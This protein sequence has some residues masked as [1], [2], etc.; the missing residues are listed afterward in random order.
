M[1]GVVI[2]GY[3]WMVK[4]WVIFGFCFFGYKNYTVNVFYFNNQKKTFAK[5]KNLN[6]FWPKWVVGRK[7]H[8][9]KSLY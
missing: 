5:I 7:E 6:T 8:E 9:A 1:S 4:L 3:L 2:S